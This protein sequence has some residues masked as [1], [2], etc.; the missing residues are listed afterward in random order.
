MK[1]I[2]SFMAELLPYSARWEYEDILP[3][4]A[5]ALH[6]LSAYRPNLNVISTS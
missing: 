4:D 2:S 5:I 1:K 6:R 3:V